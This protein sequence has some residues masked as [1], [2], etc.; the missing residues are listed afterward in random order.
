MLPEPNSGNFPRQLRRERKN[1]ELTLAELAESAEI[2][3]V[4]PGRYERGEAV[5]TMQT[6]QKLNKAL[7]GEEGEI[8]SFDSSLETATIEELVEEL[9]NRGVTKV[10][11]IF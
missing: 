5:P 6:W 10:N 9:K 2:S 3:N 8:P 7:F 4:M 1:A 11:L